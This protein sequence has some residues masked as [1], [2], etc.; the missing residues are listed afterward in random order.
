[1][2]AKKALVL[3]VENSE[4]IE[5]VTPVDVLRRAGVTW[6]ISEFKLWVVA[7]IQVANDVMLNNKWPCV[8]QVEVTV[9]GLTDTN[10]V[11]CSRQVRIVPEI[12]L[13]QALTA[14]TYDI[15]ILPGGRVGSEA[16]I[17]VRN[18]SLFCIHKKNIANIGQMCLRSTM[19]EWL[20]Y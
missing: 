4:E 6:N 13:S 20:H 2:P 3:V 16:F 9:A 15:I 18:C 17:E 12:T 14:N 19:Y 5:V 7:C 11:V 8:K 1:M 10:P